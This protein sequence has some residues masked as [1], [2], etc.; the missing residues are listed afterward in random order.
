MSLLYEGNSSE[1]RLTNEAF[2]FAQL[3]LGGN[4]D[5]T[6]GNGGKVVVDVNRLDGSSPRPLD[7]LNKVVLGPSGEI[8]AVGMASGPIGNPEKGIDFIALNSNGSLKQD[9][10]NAGLYSSGTY[11]PWRL[12]LAQDALLTSNG[13]LVISGTH[14]PDQQGPDS[15]VLWAY[16]IKPET[17]GSLP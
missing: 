6:F 8:Y 16:S 3:T 17:G 9:F 5:L 13:R 1:A 7:E 2:A 15:F 10:G 14:W 12:W 4:P 11:S